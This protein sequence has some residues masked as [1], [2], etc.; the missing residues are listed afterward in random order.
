M[1]IR[2]LR[3]RSVSYTTVASL[4]AVRKDDP[5]T[6]TPLNC[7]FSYLPSVLYRAGLYY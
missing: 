2:Q 6:G 1:R 7:W 4:P 3:I 5:I